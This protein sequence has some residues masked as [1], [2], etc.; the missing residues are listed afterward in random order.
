[1]DAVIRLGVLD[2]EMK[3]ASGDLIVGAQE[4]DVGLIL[5]ASEGLAT[6]AAG[7]LPTAQK[8]EAWPDTDDFARAYVPILESV[9][10]AAESTS[11][12]LRNGDSE[13]FVVE[14]GRL[15]TAMADY[16]RIRSQLADLVAEAALMRRGI[17]K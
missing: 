12:A 13:A 9:R 15:G 7:Y 8:L 17:H 5:G 4:Q 16:E 2:T 1:M 14:L 10:A 11:S 6:L 3:K